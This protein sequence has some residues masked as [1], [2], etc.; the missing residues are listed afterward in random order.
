MKVYREKEAKT[1]REGVKLVSSCDV[2]VVRS[3]FA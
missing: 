2:V 3:L 1:E